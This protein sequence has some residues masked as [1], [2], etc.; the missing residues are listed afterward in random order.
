MIV[1]GS[2]IEPTRWA[3]NGGWTRELAVVD[4][5]TGMRWRLSMAI[6]DGEGEFSSLPEVAR[7][8]LLVSGSL[9]L[10][11]DGG[12][13]K[14]LVDPIIFD[15]ATPIRYRASEP[16]EDLGVMV[17]GG[18]AAPLTL[19]QGTELHLEPARHRGAVVLAGS[20]FVASER[21]GYRDT[22][23]VEEAISLKTS[24]DALITIIG[25]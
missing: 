8:L 2:S 10:S 13:W 12:E 25:K 5:P 16:S 17:W 9:A 15:G 21:L 19:W 24:A 22:V 14:N 6:C 4:E 18:A 1:C 3:N 20:A 23:I 11:I 7:S